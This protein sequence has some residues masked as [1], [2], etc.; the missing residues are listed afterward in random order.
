MT[1]RPIIIRILQATPS[2]PP[3]RIPYIGNCTRERTAA[4]ANKKIALDH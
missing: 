2:I 3:N 4:N 1:P